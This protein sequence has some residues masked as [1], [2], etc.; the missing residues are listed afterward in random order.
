M[1]L[2][3]SVVFFFG[4]IIGVFMCLLMENSGC[5][6]LQQL[7]YSWVVRIFIPTCLSEPLVDV[8]MATWAC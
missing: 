7:M 4:A 3:D 5:V 2:F 8:F 1:L 6:D